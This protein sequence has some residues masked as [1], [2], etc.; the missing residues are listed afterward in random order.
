MKVSRVFLSLI[1]S[2]PIS[3][4]EVT[5]TIQ[6]MP[7]LTS[8]KPVL[9]YTS[10]NCDLGRSA[11]DSFREA[12]SDLR[13]MDISIVD[14]NKDAYKIFGGFYNYG[15]G[16]MILLKDGKVLE[17]SESYIEKK[18]GY[19]EPALVGNNQKRVWLS[20][21]I[22]KHKLNASLN[23]IPIDRADP[24][25]FDSTFDLSKAAIGFF[26]FKNGMKDTITPNG[27]SF[28]IR[29]TD[30]RLLDDAIYGTGKY[31]SNS[32]ASFSSQWTNPTGIKSGVS[33]FM[34]FNLNTEGKTACM[35]AIFS[36]LDRQISFG[37]YRGRLFISLQ[38]WNG[39]KNW[40]DV[41]YL[42]ETNIKLNEW[43][44]LGFALDPTKK[45]A[46]VQLNGVRLKDLI[47]TDSYLRAL[48][49]K[50]DFP[51]FNFELVHFGCGSVLSG[52]VDRIAIY[53]RALGAKEMKAFFDERSRKGSG[54]IT[55][56]QTIDISRVNKEYV[57]FAKEGNLKNLKTALENGAD[58]NYQH[59]GWTALMYAAYFG[60]TSIVKELIKNRINPLAEISGYTAQR[61][62]EFQNHSEIVKLLEDY[63]N[64]ESFYFQRKMNFS[65]NQK[66]SPIPP[67]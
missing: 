38:V 12:F 4:A 54:K 58:I 37:T 30:F 63:S 18:E 43:N 29:G 66:S 53:E 55:P 48:S 41:Y 28:Q 5:L 10:L 35:D 20:Q 17:S 14:T 59:E 16:T 11:A 67:P 65:V 56:M 21:M 2:L 24:L 1:L 44:N 25:I 64:T 34:D 9:A 45:R 51:Y 57:S 3:A 22:E 19:F 61:L 52:F 39:N 27:K 8:K 23:A 32:N 46:Y 49:Q 40:G 36:T 15:L 60:H 31:K 42:T 26:N 47:L 62:A 33:I 6:N 13:G 50:K 7:E